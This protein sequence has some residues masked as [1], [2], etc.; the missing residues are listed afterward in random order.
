[1]SNDVDVPRQDG[2]KEFTETEDSAP[3]DIV[4]NL[5]TKDLQNSISIRIT[6]TRS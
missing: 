1:M 6:A 4:A 2:S 3:K 5:E